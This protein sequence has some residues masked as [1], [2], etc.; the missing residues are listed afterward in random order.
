MALLKLAAN[1][2]SLGLYLKLSDFKSA[3]ILA[4]I[5]IATLFASIIA[6]FRYL[7]HPRL[8]V[9]ILLQDEIPNRKARQ[10][11]YCYKLREL[12]Q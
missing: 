3:N 11:A 12:M 6:L 10:L 8:R 7:S 4:L 9:P 2:H 1:R 5:G